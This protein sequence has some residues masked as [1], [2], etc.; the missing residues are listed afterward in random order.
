M[1]VTI[2]LRHLRHSARKLQPVARLFQGKNLHE[3]LSAVTVMP[4]HSAAHISKALKMAQA[5][6]KQKEYNPDTLIVTEIFATSGPKI[7]RTR[8]NARGR[9]NRF[10]KHLAH[11]TVTLNE[12]VQPEPTPTK[13]AKTKPAATPTEKA[14]TGR[15]AAKVQKTKAK[16]AK[17]E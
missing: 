15:K 3:A 11:L 6:A 16:G 14:Q 7:K 4:Q 1:S 8:P 13:P 12:A 10:I 17:K 5:A 9:S 2:K